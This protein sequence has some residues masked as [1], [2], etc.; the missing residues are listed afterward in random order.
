[1]IEIVMFTGNSCGKCKGAKFNL[2][3]LPQFAKDNLNLIEKNVDEKEEYMEELTK[4]I[5]VSKLPTFII[6]GDKKNPL[7]G[8]EEN[9][10]KIQEVLGL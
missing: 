1:M 8:F 6:D 4:E 10:G 2:S 9:F 7:V 5:G 3:N